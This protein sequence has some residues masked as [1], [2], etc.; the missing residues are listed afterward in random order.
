MIGTVA[1]RDFGDD[2]A[3]LKRMFVDHDYH[4]KGVGQKLLDHALDFAKVQGFREVILNT[5]PLMKRAHRF[6]EKNGFVKVGDDTF[7]VHYRRMLK[8]E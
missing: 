7:P 2:I 1:I 4:G 6:Y 8:Q 3:K 5:H